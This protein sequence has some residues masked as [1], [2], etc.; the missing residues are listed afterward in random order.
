MRLDPQSKGVVVTAVADGSTAQSIGFRKGDIVLSVNSQNV[1]KSADL[2]R[3]AKAGGRQ[4]RITI[5]RGG[6]EISVVFSG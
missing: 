6:Q 5:K 1:V 4:W 2:E 3:I